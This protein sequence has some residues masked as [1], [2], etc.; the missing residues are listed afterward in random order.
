[1]SRF[2]HL[3]V[4]QAFAVLSCGAYWLGRRAVYPFSGSRSRA[5]VLGSS[6]FL[7]EGGGGYACSVAAANGADEGTPGPP[8]W[9]CVVVSAT[10]YIAHYSYSTGASCPFVLQ[11]L[12]NLCPSTSPPKAG[13]VAGGRRPHS[14]LPPSRRT[15][16]HVNATTV[17]TQTRPPAKRAGE[18]LPRRPPCAVLRAP[19]LH[20]PQLE[21]PQCS[22]VPK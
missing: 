3:Q 11:S 9:R 4:L 5:E 2:G 10:K 19:Q 7:R 17:A 13:G 12:S 22:P 6:W 16:P 20:A 15:N 18:R 21:A 14:R 1:M 8:T